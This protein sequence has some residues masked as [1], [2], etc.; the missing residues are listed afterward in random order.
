MNDPSCVAL[1]QWALPR[2]RL[3]WPGFRRVHG[4]VCKRLDRRRAALGLADLGAY[5]RWLER[6]P[7]EWAILDELCR[8]TISRFGRDREIWAALVDD[9]LPRL[10]REAT[11]SG[12]PRIAAWSAGC[13]A[14]EEPYTLAIAWQLAIAPRWPA[15]TLDVLATDRDRHQ[16]E[17]A[18]AAIYPRGTLRELPDAW[19][20]RAFE[21]C[22]G[23]RAQ[24]RAPFRAGVRFAEHDVRTPPP[25]GPF[26]LVLCRNLA[27]TYF[28]EALQREVATA[29]RDTLRA[30]G[31]VVVGNHERLP[32]GV[33]GLAPQ[34]R[35]VYVVT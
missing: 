21:P 3:R 31:V 22:D 24:L 14:G 4:Q 33:A 15:L 16:L 13:G 10:A 9:V 30:G 28:D 11:S 20:A 35:G 1:L 7:A 6:E 34:A 32:E 8:V 25:D 19:R 18:R 17:R 27:F 29:L 26:D 5:R 2:L 23:D 12:R